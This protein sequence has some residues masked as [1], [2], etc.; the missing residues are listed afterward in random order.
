M[1][2]RTEEVCGYCL[3]RRNLSS[4]EVGNIREPWDP[5]VVWDLRVIV[6]CDWRKLKVVGL[7]GVRTPAY[8]I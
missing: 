6:L 2:S 1:V 4:G 3:K 8:L 5:R 7:G